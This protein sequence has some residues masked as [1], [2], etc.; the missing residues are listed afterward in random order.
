[1][2]AQIVLPPALSIPAAPSG[3][4]DAAQTTLAA[5]PASAGGVLAHHGAALEGPCSAAAPGRLAAERLCGAAPSRVLEP[6]GDIFADDEE[7]FEAEAAAS[8]ASPLNMRRTTVML[9]RLT[10]K[11]TEAEV[12]RALVGVGL[13]GRY[14]IVYVPLN[15]RR[16]SN[17]GYAFVDFHTA[18]GAQECFRRVTN[19][20]LPG[21]TGRRTCRVAFSKM[22]GSDFVRHVR[23]ARAESEH[24][25]CGESSDPPSPAAPC[26]F[27]AP[28][29]ALQPSSCGATSCSA[30]PVDPSSLSWPMSL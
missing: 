19:R 22:Q 10:P 2:F 6:A 20:A 7:F 13:G 27:Q 5:Q 18:E 9:Q 24:L 1:M 16:T 14:S 4:Q 30:G 8:T 17:L 29:P 23:D 11:R 12:H 15:R 25:S 3:G 26:A 21:L 28:E